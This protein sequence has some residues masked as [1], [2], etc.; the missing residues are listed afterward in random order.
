M[1]HV[2]DTYCSIVERSSC[3]A[4]KWIRTGLPDFKTKIPV[5]E[6]FGGPWNEKA[7]YNLWPFGICIL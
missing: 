5:W 6:N 4:I 1:K 3:D 7:G 2:S